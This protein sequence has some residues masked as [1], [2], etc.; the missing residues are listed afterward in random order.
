MRPKRAARKRMSRGDERKYG[1]NRARQ[2]L[3][4]ILA[5]H[6]AIGIELRCHVE[7]FVVVRFD[8]LSRRRMFRF[9]M[10]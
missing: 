1:R 3:L 4:E 5:R 9:E 2:P 6:S 7:E 10:Q 8:L